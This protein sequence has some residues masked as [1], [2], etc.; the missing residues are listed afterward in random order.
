MPPISAIV[1][2]HNDELRIGR[3]LQTLPPCDEILII[4]HG[5][6]DLTLRIAREY[7]ARIFPAERSPADQLRHACNEWL[8]CL[9]PNESLSEGLEA[10]LF[11]WRQRSKAEVQSVFAAAIVPRT[12][13]PSGWTQT[14]P[15]TRLVPKTWPQWQGQLPAHDPQAI[16][17][18]GDLL[19]F[20]LP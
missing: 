16:V 6:T 12:E 20:S 7:A 17:L 10:T 2:T 1:H 5:S 13:T 8:L 19:R 4:D 3:L 18:Q 11:E 9:R 15:E 14:L